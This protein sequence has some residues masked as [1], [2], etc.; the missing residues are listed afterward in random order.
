MFTGSTVFSQLLDYIPR[1]AFQECVSRY[2]G[3]LRLRNFSCR[4]Q[5]L[6]LAFAQLTY[7]ESLRDIETCLH[8]LGPKLYHSGF[9]GKVRRS[10]LADANRV[11]DWRIFHDFAQILIR[12]GR[13]LY[14]NE[15]FGLRLKKTVYAFDSSTV[16]LCLSMFP[17]AKFRRRKAA[18]KLHTLLDIRGNIPC[19]IHVSQGKLHDV[20]ALDLL[21]IEANSF[22]VMDRGYLDFKRL[23]RFT[24][25]GAFFVIRA[26]SNLDFRRCLRHPVDTKVGL[27]SDVIIRLKGPLSA[28]NYP[29]RLRRISFHDAEKDRRLVFLTNNTNLAAITIAK[30]YRCR[31]QVELFFKWIKQNLRIKAFYGTSE[32]AVKTQIWIAIAIYVLVAIV[33]KDLKIERSQSETLQILSL[34]LFEKMPLFQ[35]FSMENPEKPD[36]PCHNQRS[37]FDL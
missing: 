36:D 3:D 4:D 29:D 2:K 34:T 35:A 37:L 24:T 30:L 28:K 33:R 22:Y 10:T 6:T 25:A 19:F 27:R 16:D 32:N 26:K 21:P 23:Y 13:D 12:Q 5:F 18:I 8:A 15:P 20:N 31:W 14:A 11:H 9:R 17:W 1:R 7:R